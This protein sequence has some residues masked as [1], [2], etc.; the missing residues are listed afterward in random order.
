MSFFKKIFNKKSEITTV[1]PLPD[2]METQISGNNP[3]SGKYKCNGTQNAIY[4][5]YCDFSTSYKWIFDSA[6]PASY[7]QNYIKSLQI[8]KELNTYKYKHFFKPPTPSQQINEL[9][10]NYI[11][12]TNRFI[13]K[14]WSSTIRA[15]EKL[16]T[17]RGKKN[18]INNFYDSLL[19]EYHSYLT[20]ENIAYINSLKSRDISMPVRII[21]QEVKCGKYNV[22]SIDGINSIPNSAF[23]VIRLLQ[24]AATAHKRNGD[25]DLAIEC[26]KKSNLINDNL[27]PHS[28]IPKLTEKE[29]LRVIKY[30]N[31]YNSE[32]A[33]I[34]EA[35]IY[36]KHPEIRDKRISNKKHIK[37][38]LKKCNEWGCD[39]IEIFTD[40]SCS[41]CS[42]YDKKIYSISGKSLKYPKL[43][44]EIKNQTHNCKTCIM[45]AH[46]VWKK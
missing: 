34:E 28:Q 35:V 13:E 42:K 6:K 40:S 38:T 12:N 36:K 43:P 22:N 20:D 26:L 11:E 3:Y 25:M 1:I 15:T 30:L 41:I 33:K 32:Q 31:Q 46:S 4:L 2:Y 37:E 19:N 10:T 39:L 17:E 5:L 29:Y 27:P 24:K 18:R 16:K 8:L 7:F 9:R 45:T 44:D 23:D 21:K 14:Y